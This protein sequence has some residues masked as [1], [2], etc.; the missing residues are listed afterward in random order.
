MGMR[1]AAALAGLTF[2]GLAGCTTSSPDAAPSRAATSSTS[3]TSSTSA[4]GAAKTVSHLGHLTFLP[5]ATGL[6]GR[7][8]VLHSG[9]VNF[10]LAMT[11]RPGGWPRRVRI[12]VGL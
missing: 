8:T 9:Q 12:A 7:R 1:P 5:G 2:V 10:A 11:I 6:L 3:S 4:G